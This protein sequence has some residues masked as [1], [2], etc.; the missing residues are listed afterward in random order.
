MIL[1]HNKDSM[2]FVKQFLMSCI[3][4]SPAPDKNVQKQQIEKMF[5]DIADKSSSINETI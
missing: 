4:L 1:L 3:D 5:N 2:D